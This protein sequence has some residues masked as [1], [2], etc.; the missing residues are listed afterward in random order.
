MNEEI[1]RIYKNMAAVYDGQPWY[2]DNL[3]KLLADVSADVAVD[4]PNKLNHSIVEIVCHI[5]AWRQFVIEK[6][7]GNAEYEVWDTELNW[8]KI[9][10]LSEPQWK[11]IKDDLQNGQTELLQLVEKLSEVQLS[12]PVAGRK[13]NFRLMLQGIV[14][15]DIYHLGQISMIKK[16]S[17]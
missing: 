15:H 5:T 16:L 4:R 12:A 2:G 1:K 9:K 7:K 3:V 10:S 14:Q 8:Q 6:I 13:Y 11:S 17:G